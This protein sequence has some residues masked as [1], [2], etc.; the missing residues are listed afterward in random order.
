ML[1]C[2]LQVAA[3]K[4]KKAPKEE[5]ENGKKAGKERP[6]KDVE[7]VPQKR[8]PV[9]KAAPQKKADDYLGDLDLPSS[10]SEDE[11]EA[12]GYRPL[13]KGADEAVKTVPQVP[14]QQI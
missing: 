9:L 5:R 4:K 10:S 2:A 6:V 8:Q 12:E 13:Y 11:T 3:D 1:H 7:D 14:N